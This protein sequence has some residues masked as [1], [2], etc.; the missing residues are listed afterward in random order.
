MGSVPGTRSWPLVLRPLV[1]RPYLMAAIVCGVVFYFAAAPWVERSVTRA[2][3]GWNGG[4]VV[5][6][7]LA[8]F[9]MSNADAEQMKRRAV[10]HD[11]GGHL[12]LILTILASIASV[13]ALVAEL[14]AAKAHPGGE[15]RVALAAG[16]VVLSWLFV[17]IV[18][19]MHYAHLYYLAE[20]SGEPKGGLE[21]GEAGE[22][23]YWDFVHFSIVMGAT[24]QTADITF[25][26]KAM[27]RV[28]TLHTLV[29]FGFNTA[30]L[31]TM[32]NLAAN[33]F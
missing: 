13:G 17:Q 25:G 12:M 4:V 9:F 31:A 15:L 32:I 7:C 18:F 27:R 1:G 26:S 2:L 22:P 21:F 24:A 3:I 6:L 19:A 8:F 16:T 29:A 11:E 14:S 20:D 33:L 23:D 5:F 28:G 30:I 10:A